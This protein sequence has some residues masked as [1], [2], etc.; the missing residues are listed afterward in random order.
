MGIGMFG[1]AVET[2]KLVT[3]HFLCF[4]K[5]KERGKVSKPLSNV[6]GYCI[7]NKKNM[8]V[9]MLAFRLSLML[10]KNVCDKL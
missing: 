3:I 2:K 1:G 8:H 9:K 5:A 10:Y 6:R 7:L 4:K